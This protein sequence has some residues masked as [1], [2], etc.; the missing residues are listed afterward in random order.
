MTQA[1]IEAEASSGRDWFSPV[2]DSVLAAMRRRGVA[3]AELGGELPGGQGQL[4]GIVA[5]DADLD[6]EA[7]EILAAKLGGSAS[8]WL[9]RQKD[10]ELALEKSLE[11]TD[12]S[13]RAIWLGK[14]PLPAKG[15]INAKNS[16][17]ELARRLRFYGVSSLASWYIQYGKDR[18]D[19]KFRSSASFTSDEG[20]VSMWLRQGE[21]EASLL[22]TGKW[23]LEKL[24][25][26][27]PQLRTLSRFSQPKIFV[28]QLRS[29]L[30]QAGVA[31]VFVRGPK[32]CRASGASRMMAA[33]KAMVLVSFRHR[34][35]DQFWFTLFHEL[36]HLILHNGGS[37][38][39]TE[40]QSLDRFEEEANA[41]A[42]S[43]IVPPERVLEMERLGPSSKAVIAFARKIG[44]CPGLVLGQLQHRGLRPFSRSS[45]LQRT[46]TWEEIEEA[47]SV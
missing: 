13:E 34:S 18:A 41:F 29:L 44:V 11:A 37:F 39:D 9:Q 16:R 36:G 43:L 32:G 2:A 27:L 47:F 38:I 21:L 24:K 30:A 4:R 15:R 26:L 45:K 6:A 22:D 23:D 28:P 8:F 46:W 7:A 10:F 12:E 5:G 42:E 3:A 25:A 19:T 33:D 35:D 14:I 17:A 1:M 31:F 40:D 20:A